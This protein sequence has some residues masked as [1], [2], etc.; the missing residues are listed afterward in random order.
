[1]KAKLTTKFVS[2]ARKIALEKASAIMGGADIQATINGLLIAWRNQANGNGLVFPNSIKGSRLTTIKKPRGAVLK[3]A[4]IKDFRF[5]DLRHH[6]A[7]SL[8]MAGADL[9][10]VRELLG[11]ADL[12]MALR[13]AHLAPKH[14]AAAVALLD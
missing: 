14:K 10:T 2:A 1:M 5:H 9:N 7:S 12:T 6:F 11:H 4:N 13:Y 3:A 8:V